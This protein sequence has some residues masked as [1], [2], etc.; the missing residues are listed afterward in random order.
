M[1]DGQMT[2]TDLDA[3]MLDMGRRARAA[4]T[5]LAE[6]TGPQRSATLSAMADALTAAGADILAANARDVERARVNG[7]GEA[8][9]D[10]LALSPA[11]V[12]AMVAA[13]AEVAAF[14]DPLGVET[15]RWTRPNGL[16]IA[17]VRTPLGVLAI[18]YEP[19]CDGRRRRPVPEVGQRRHPAL[20]FGL[21][22][23][24]SRHPRGHGVGSGGGGPAGRRRPAGPHP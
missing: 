2:N 10:R 22:G 7:L 13:V 14:P 21:S 11:R 1:A 20:R 9:I 18:I 15:E 23:K 16:D 4:A 24:Q 17:R 5:L 12:Q 19:E 6:A 8:L 3:L